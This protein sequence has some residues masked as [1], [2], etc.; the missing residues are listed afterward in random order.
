MRTEKNITAIGHQ[1][2][3]RRRCDDIQLLFAKNTKLDLHDIWFQQDGATC[4]TTR[5]TFYF[6]FGTF[7]LFFV[8]L[9]QSSCHTDKPASIDALEDNIVTFI[10]EIPVEILEKV[11]QNWT[12]R[13]DHLKRSRFTLLL[14]LFS[15]SS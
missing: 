7:G 4:H 15:Y 11:C 13:M 3:I 1:L 12:K 9:C 8:G 14:L 10:R 6:R 5:V 2:S